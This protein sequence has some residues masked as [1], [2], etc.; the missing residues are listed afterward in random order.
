MARQYIEAMLAMRWPRAIAD[1]LGAAVASR[2]PGLCA[3]CRAWG[4]GRV[5]ADCLGRFA[6]PV[7]RC[8]RCALPV[9]PTTPVCGACLTMPPAFD[10][11]LA[12]VGYAAP[13]DRLVTAFKFHDALDLAPVFAGALEVAEKQRDAPRPS[14]LLPVP[15]APRRLRE[16][17]YNQAWE[18]AR[19]VARRLAIAAESELLLRIRETAHQLAL[20]LAERAGNVRGAFAV[21]PGR[22]TELAGRHVAIVDDVMTTGVTAAEIA[23]VLK[24]SGAATVEVWVL[25]RTPRPGDA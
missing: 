16:R 13:W 9:G 4:R 23:G 24:Q 11:A 6:A 19:R 5:C 7:P 14:L 21:E 18:L 10:A 1:S 15:L 25:A 20:P 3:V 17:G 12:A 8:R 22:R 2:G